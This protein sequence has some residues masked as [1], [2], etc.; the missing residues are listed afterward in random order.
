MKKEKTTTLLLIL[1]FGGFGIHHFYLGRIT[2]G[3]LSIF[4]FWTLIPA[5]VSF[6]NLFQIAILSEENFDKKYGNR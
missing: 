3:V 4:F 5:I 2:A 6:V 1:F